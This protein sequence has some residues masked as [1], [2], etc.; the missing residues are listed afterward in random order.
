VFP[1]SRA[2]AGPD[3]RGPHGR[4]N[5]EIP[6]IMSQ[7]FARILV[8][9]DGSPL[10]EHALAYAAALSQP[11]STVTLLH[12]DT[13]EAAT[14]PA[15]LE[16]VVA[17][18]SGEVPIDDESQA[19]VLTAVAE[20]WKTSIKGAVT[21][22]VIFG[23]PKTE[24]L[25]TADES[26][27]DVIVCATRGRGAIGRWAFGSVADDLARSATIPVLVVR[28]SEDEIAPGAA[29][30]ARIV[31][32]Y[33]GSELADSAQPVAISLAETLGLPVHVISAYDPGPVGPIST[34]MDAAYPLTAYAEIQDELEELAKES[35]A[36]AETT[37]KDAGLTVTTAVHLGPPALVIEDALA[38][39]DLIVMTSRGRGGLQ[40]AVL[41]S[42]AE[43]LIR[44]GK[45][46]TVLV[47]V[48]RTAAA[49]A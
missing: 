40:R 24:I 38:A 44:D 23:D 1:D 13:P 12:V 10:S 20:R 16:V 33:D 11:G 25:R 7:S 46:P 34:G 43:K 37:F 3:D 36:K 15:M 35:V 6:K 42:V 9:L 47:P 41:G 30:L 2:D 48:A 29:T 8:P 26:N 14:N 39:N 28:A 17:A 4:A 31:F 32:P 49:E 18:Q 21:T 27:A 19:S 5:E 22:S 45:A